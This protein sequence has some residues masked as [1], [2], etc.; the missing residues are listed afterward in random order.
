MQGRLLPGVQVH[1]SDG[2]EEDA[3]EHQEAVGAAHVGRVPGACSN[4]GDSLS[5][6]G[7]WWEGIRKKFDCRL[8]VAQV[9]R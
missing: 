2:W 7:L 1:T 5:D 4:C 8:T 3:E 9:D 6:S